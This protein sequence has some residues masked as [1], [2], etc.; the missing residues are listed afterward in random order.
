MNNRMFSTGTR[1][2]AKV[3]GVLALAAMLFAAGCIVVPVEPG[4]Y[5]Y[6][7]NRPCHRGHCR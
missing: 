2:R 5:N 1:S 7:Y 6:P 4:P 3:F